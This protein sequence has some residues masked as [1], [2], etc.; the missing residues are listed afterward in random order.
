MFIVV[1]LQFDLLQ[2]SA[3]SARLKLLM[4]CLAS[5]N[6]LLLR[7]GLAYSRRPRDCYSPED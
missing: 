4:C 6:I 3:F 5:I 2:P 7:S 1:D